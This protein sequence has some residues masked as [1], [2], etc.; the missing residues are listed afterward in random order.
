MNVPRAT[1]ISL[2]NQGSIVI[3]LAGPVDG[4]YVRRVGG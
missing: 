3:G 2:V 4:L 1:L